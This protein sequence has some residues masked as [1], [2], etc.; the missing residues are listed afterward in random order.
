MGNIKIKE[1]DIRCPDIPMFVPVDL[2]DF[3]LSDTEI[4]ILK[5]ADLVSY[6]RSLEKTEDKYKRVRAKVEENLNRPDKLEKL[7]KSEDPIVR[8]IVAESLTITPD[9]PEELVKKLVELAEKLAN[10]PEW[11]VRA[12]LAG[13]TNIKSDIFVKLVEKLAED[14]HWFV[15]LS[16]MGND[17]APLKIREKLLEDNAK[18]VEDLNCLL[19][20]SLPDFYPAE[21][22]IRRE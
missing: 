9:M 16:V 19:P 1:E 15:I 10:D 21:K 5:D 11:F 20:D 13:N 2:L 8:G 18:L 12:K 14:K 4:Q 6:W 17:H 22:N 7:A 3:Y